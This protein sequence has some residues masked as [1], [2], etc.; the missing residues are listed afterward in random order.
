MKVRIT[1]A[2]AFAL[3]FA[4]TCGCIPSDNGVKVSENSFFDRMIVKGDSVYLICCVEFINEEDVKKTFSVKGESE[5]DVKNGLLKAKELKCFILET[6]DIAT[7]NEDNI[8]DI[9]K[10]A[11]NIEVSAHGMEKYYVCFVGDHGSGE[12]KSNRNLPK[13]II[14]EK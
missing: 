1:I 4:F 7:V 5:E 8:E 12:S 3:L 11:E 14:E 13:I 6:N 2:L 10:S 9:L